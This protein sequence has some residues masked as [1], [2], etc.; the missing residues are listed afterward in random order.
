MQ[1]LQFR[2]HDGDVSARGFRTVARF[3]VEVA[4][5]ITIQDWQLVETPDG[6]HLAYPP[7]GA[8]RRPTTLIRPEIRS[9][10]IDRAVELINAKHA[11]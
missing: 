9:V 3:A 6:N 10:I 2:H 5:G 4:P 11:A 8:N 1:I 7:A